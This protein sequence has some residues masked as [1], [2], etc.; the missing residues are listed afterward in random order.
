[1]NSTSTVQLVSETSPTKPLS[2]RNEATSS[3]A[4]QVRSCPGNAPQTVWD[5]LMYPRILLTA[6]ICAV[7]TVLHIGFGIYIWLFAD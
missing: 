5:Y 3:R 2:V 7:S 6:I 1:M 4:P